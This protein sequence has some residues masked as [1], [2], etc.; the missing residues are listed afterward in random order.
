MPG[1]PTD[2][3]IRARQQMEPAWDDLREQRVLSRI[4]AAR[5]SRAAEGEAPRQPRSTVR[6]RYR[7][8]IPLFAAAVAAV[9]LVAWLGTRGE[10][11]IATN[12]ASADA[13]TSP[14]E[15]ARL[16]LADGSIALLSRDARVRVDRQNE[17]EVS[18]AQQSGSVTYDVV[19][20]PERAFVVHALHATVTVRGT[21]FTVAIDDGF[22][23]VDVEEGRVEV[24][25]G[26]ETTV[27]GAGEQIR[28]GPPAEPATAD[29]DEGGAAEGNAR[30]AAPS[31]V[32]G[33]APR[34]DEERPRMPTRARASDPGEDVAPPPTLEALQRDA[35]AA[36]RAG[37]VDDAARILRSAIETH[38]NDPRAPGAL[39]TLGRLERRRGEHAE[40]ARAFERARA[41]APSGPLAEDALAEEAISWRDA[42]ETLRAAAA[43]R[44]YLD[45]YPDGLHA[46]RMRT[47]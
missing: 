23:G 21:R 44:R 3:A 22:V 19:R 45:L 20:A 29:R 8:A 7:R 35:D 47:P 10:P 4:V 41:L 30:E 11:P 6:D 43:A 17:R 5:R 31:T 25:A 12:E 26:Q 27:L 15:P 34:A 37:R 14:G 46:P 38:P 9:A 28:V 13:V 1:E 42:G 2:E 24:R 18:I 40:A 32:G 33:E 16:D 36:R 39:F